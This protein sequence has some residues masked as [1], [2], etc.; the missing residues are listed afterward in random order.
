MD[1][2][3]S[4]TDKR[5]KQ[6]RTSEANEVE[7]NSTSREPTIET[8]GQHNNSSQFRNEP[9]SES[10]S[11][12]AS[13]SGGQAAGAINSNADRIYQHQEAHSDTQSTSHYSHGSVQRDNRSNQQTQDQD[14]GG[15]TGALNGHRPSE[16][17]ED[18]N[19]MDDTS[20]TAN[21]LIQDDDGDG[22]SVYTRVASAPRYPTGGPSNSGVGSRNILRL[23]R[24]GQEDETNY[25]YNDDDH[26][27]TLPIYSTRFKSGAHVYE[28]DLA[29]KVSRTI[30]K[31]KPTSPSTSLVS[32]ES[33]KKGRDKGKREFPTFKFGGFGGRGASEAGPSTERQ[34]KNSSSSLNSVESDI[35]GSA[36]SEAIG[37]SESTDVFSSFNSAAANFNDIP[38]PPS[39][40]CTAHTSYNPFGK[41]RALF[42]TIYKYGGVPRRQTLLG[43][44]VFQ[45]EQELGLISQSEEFTAPGGVDIPESNLNSHSKVPICKV[46]QEVVRGSIDV[47]RYTIEFENPLDFAQPSITMINDGSK[48]VTD[49]AYDGVRMRWYGTT[50]L[51]S[52]FG[53][54]FFELRFVDRPNHNILQTRD[55]AIDNYNQ[56]PAQTQ[57]QP[58]LSSPSRPTPD[59]NPQNSSAIASVQGTGQGGSSFSNARRHTN[60]MPY[61]QLVRMRQ[62]QLD[63]ERRR[64]PV[65]LYHNIST[66]TLASTR[67]VGEFTIWEPGYELSDIIIMMGLVLREQ[68]QRK[69]VEYQHVVTS[70]IMA[71]MVF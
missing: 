2:L 21:T 71:S 14:G 43:R 11:A 9:I 57:A 50:G 5:K 25:Q 38:M 7:P 53:S 15:E 40:G 45:R 44:F 8:G 6:R 23:G 27:K 61:D 47:V 26:S 59:D 69:D 54:G 32:P 1:W 37:L 35:S 48:R 33:D 46:W 16:S 63:T 55:S 39:I 68:E 36:I 70:K 42:M 34:R 19:F 30:L 65:A 10:T 66:K 51:A 29:A 64:P 17:S 3:K 28:S 18:A 49:A 41:S 60:E 67:K 52:T 62:E 31:R 13:S 12:V 22:S 56:A 20:S 24:H 4:L 58:A